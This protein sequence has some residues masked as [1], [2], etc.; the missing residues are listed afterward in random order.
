[1]LKML[2]TFTEQGHLGRQWRGCDCKCV[3]L[4]AHDTYVLDWLA[5]HCFLKWILIRT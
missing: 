1:M 2:A 3:H 4:Y 5:S